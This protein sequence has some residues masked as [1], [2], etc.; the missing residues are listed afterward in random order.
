M[1][2]LSRTPTSNEPKTPLLRDNP[3][4]TGDDVFNLLNKSAVRC[5][6]C[7]R[8]VSKGH[9]TVVSSHVFCPDHKEDGCRTGDVNHHLNVWDFIEHNDMT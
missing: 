5:C 9:I 3:W 8:V 2:Y 1:G 7:N 4:G 6:Y